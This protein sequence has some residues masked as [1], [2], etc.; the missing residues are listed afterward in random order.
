[1]DCRV[2]AGAGLFTRGDA[3]TLGSRPKPVAS[4]ATSGTAT[5][6]AHIARLTPSPQSGTGLPARAATEAAMRLP[7]HREPSPFAC[8][9]QEVARRALRAR[10]PG[11]QAR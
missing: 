11:L 5:I 7:L 3:T 1:M 6:R 9:E 10:S 8:G 4:K 2:K